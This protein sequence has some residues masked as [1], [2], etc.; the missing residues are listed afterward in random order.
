MIGL[1]WLA[2]VRLCVESVLDLG[3]PGD[4][5]ETGVWRGGATIFMRAILKSHGVTDRLVWVADSFAGLPPPDAAR[6]PLDEGITLHRFAQLAVPQECVQENFRR[7]GLLDLN[8]IANTPE[9]RDFYGVSSVILMPSLWHESLGRV[10]IEAMANGIPVLASDRG[11]LPE[12]LGAA[13]FVFTIPERCTPTSHVVPTAQEVAPWV[14]VI[15]RLWDDPEFEAEHRRRALAEAKRWD[16]ERVA[17]QF[18]DFFRTQLS[19]R[20]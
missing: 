11:A 17:E 10:P 5:I 15:E 6:Y 9:P 14:A 2:N 16:G 20:S 12:T 18:E 3:V 7:Y 8:R 19:D 4:L 1:K 13:G